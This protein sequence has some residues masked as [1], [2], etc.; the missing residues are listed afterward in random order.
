M[1]ARATRGGEINGIEARVLRKK[2][3]VRVAN[4]FMERI[5]I[6]PYTPMLTMACKDDLT[7]EQ[8]RAKG[9]A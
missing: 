4:R 2:Y 8:C 5:G 3:A 1:H 9:E 6:H 7:R